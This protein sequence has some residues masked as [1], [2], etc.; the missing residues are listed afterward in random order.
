MPKNQGNKNTP[1][2][3]AISPGAVYALAGE[4][5]SKARIEWMINEFLENTLRSF[6]ARPGVGDTLYI[7]H[8][9]CVK[10]THRHIVAFNVHYESTILKNGFYYRFEE[11][12]SPF[13]LPDG[14]PIGFEVPEPYFDTILKYVS[15]EETRNRRVQ[16]IAQLMEAGRYLYVEKEAFLKYAANDDHCLEQ[17]EAFYNRI[18]QNSKEIS[19]RAREVL[20]IRE[21]MAMYDE[22]T[23]LVHE[24]QQIEAAINDEKLTAEDL[25]RFY[26]KYSTVV[27]R[28]EPLS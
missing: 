18:Q 5:G 11:V 15:P 8:G 13:Q 17:I 28:R 7:H 10:V 23:F 9:L 27:E 19:P 4:P 1:H 14:I 3:Y 26:R 12:N 6:G 25:R 21:D 24:K 20:I 2:T 16:E 22:G